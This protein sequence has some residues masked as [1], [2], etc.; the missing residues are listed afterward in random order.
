MLQNSSSLTSCL[1]GKENMNQG[2]LELE[3]FMMV[4][5]PQC[6]CKIIPKKCFRIPQNVFINA[7]SW[8]NLFWIALPVFFSLNCRALSSKS[9]SVS[10]TF[11]IWYFF[12]DKEIIYWKWNIS[13]RNILSNS[14][15]EWKYCH[16]VW[17][18]SLFWW[19]EFVFCVWTWAWSTKP[20]FSYDCPNFS[21]RLR[22]GDDLVIAKFSSSESPLIVLVLIVWKLPRILRAIRKIEQ[23]SDALVSQGSSHCN[24]CLSDTPYW[25]ETFVSQLVVGGIS[26]ATPDETC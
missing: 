19:N 2:T 5:L 10:M 3:I 13:S 9:Q 11:P 14:S 25:H 16:K 6:I 15:H 26:Q 17:I 7:F 1:S 18:Y 4:I 23:K 24:Y 8:K 22:Y 20:L 12:F 21:D